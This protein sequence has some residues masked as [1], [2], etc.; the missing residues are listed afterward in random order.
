MERFVILGGGAAGRRASEVIRERNQDAAISIIEEEEDPFYYR[1]LLGGFLSQKLQE[2]WIRSKDRERLLGLGIR[3]HLGARAV[4]LDAENQQILFGD[5]EKIPYDKLLIA[6]GRKAA[7]IPDVKDT[8]GIAYLDNLTD[9]RI[10]A[11]RLGTVKRAVVVGSSIP[12]LDALRGL[13]GRG[14]E[15]TYLI[16]EGRFWPGVLD[17]VGS[18]IIEEQLKAEKITLRTACDVQEVTTAA[19]EITGI[20]TTKGD[21]ISADLLVVT[22]PQVPELEFLRDADLEVDKGVVVDAS[23]RTKRENVFAAGDVAQVPLVNTQTAIPQP[24][25]LN[26]WRQGN[27]AGLN[28]VGRTATCAGVPSLRI[29]VFDLDV[30]CLGLSGASGEGIKEDSGDYPYEELPYF[31]KNLVYQNGKVIG[32]TFIGDVSEAGKVE[33]WIRKGY[34]ED[35]CDQKVMDQMFRPRITSF[36]AHG[37]LCPVCKFQIQVDEDH[38]EGS[39]VTCPACGFEFRLKRMP[40]GVFRAEAAHG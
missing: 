6:S 40:N 12:A 26:A 24:G 22:A 4:S 25:W 7:R 23:L 9:A 29:K 31:Y 38:D 39:V 10:I 2:A 5:G 8:K 27:V 34:R 1:P 17:R 14:I 15:C 28:M 3:F 32:A 20:V 13:R 21:K 11:A 37:A 18:E 19:G 16:P 33:H 35:E 36:M 30:V